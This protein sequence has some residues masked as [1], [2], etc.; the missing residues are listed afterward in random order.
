MTAPRMA[1]RAAAMLALGVM[2]TAGSA[3]AQAWVWDGRLRL[4]A[5]YKDETGDRTTMQETFNLYDGFAVSSLYL[6]AHRNPKTHLLLDLTDVNLDDRRGS[7]DFRRSGLLHFNSRYDQSRF[8]YDP[9]GNVDARRRDW[10]STLSLTPA[11]VWSLSADYGLQTRR[12]DRLGLTGPPAGWLGTGYDSDLHHWQV[13]AEAHHPSSGI[14]GSVAYNGV[15]L[16]DDIDARRER[17]GYV[18][19]ANLHLPGLWIDRLTHVA[20]ASIGR[21]ELPN[22]GNLGYDLKTIQ[23]TGILDA[24]RW[25]RLRYQFYGSQVDDEASTLRTVDIM[26][27]IDA[28]LR[29]SIAAL[30]VGYGWE[31]L[32]DDR[33][34]TTANTLRGTLVVRERKD[35]ISAHVSY[36]TRNKDDEESRTL[37]RDTEYDRFEARLEGRP[38]DAL[39]VGARIAERKRD[40]PDIGSSADGK[41]ATAF[42]TWTGAPTGNTKLLTG[43]LGVDYTYSDDDYDNIWGEEHITTHAVTGRVGMVLR[44]RID[45]D[46]AVTYLAMQDDLDVEKSILS[47]SAGYRFDNGLSADARYNIY[48]FDDYLIAQRFYTAN[49]V[50]VNVGYAFSKGRNQQ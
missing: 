6:D 27:D 47:F 35:R 37:L 3:R 13:E 11:K 39:A 20:R 36:A 29:W 30:T 31:A 38:V 45:L 40:M 21:S 12:G 25:A 2:A 4:G 14:G 50:W 49:V 18:V 17:S 1:F 5:I 26:H 7:L 34:Q 24:A 23:Y 41:V 15:R 28:T 44:Q 8:L 10:F 9:A 22:A 32:D 33:S 48:N 16:F 46:G 42:A 43:D 19:A